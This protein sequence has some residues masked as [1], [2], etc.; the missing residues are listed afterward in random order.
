MHVTAAHQR[1]RSFG[2]IKLE[3]FKNT[4]ARRIAAGTLAESDLG[5]IDQYI[6]NNQVTGRRRRAG[7]SLA[8]RKNIFNSLVTTREFLSA[9]YATCTTEDVYAAIPRF[10]TAARAD[11]KP[12]FGPSAIHELRRELKA[13]CLFL[14][15]HGY[16]THLDEK[17]IRKIAVPPPNRKTFQDTDL[18]KPEEIEA[19]LRACT[20]SRDRAIIATLYEGGL[21][22]VEIGRLKWRDVEFTQHNVRITV[23][24]KTDRIRVVPCP[25]AK[26]Y[27]A[28]WRRDCP[29]P[30]EGDNLVFCSF[31]YRTD[32]TGDRKYL[33]MLDDSLRAQL[34]DIAAR[35]GVKRYRKPYQFRHTRITDLINLGVSESHVA[36]LSHGGHTRMMEVYKHVTNSDAERAVLRALGVGF[37]EEEKPRA[38]TP[39]RCLNCGEPC[40][41]T[42][43]YCYKCGEPLTE[44]ARHR[45]EELK[46]EATALDM[47]KLARL[48][49]IMESPKFK[50]LEKLILGE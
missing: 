34:K 17:R 19:M 45:R 33:P 43:D 20:N 39:K 11:G 10:E 38:L 41:P 47:T 42:S 15:E 6:H 18:L 31:R 13:F 12:R 30:P 37:G 32:A 22:P 40:G 25:M 9:P 21:R 35:A 14:I 3:Y 50:E 4:A 46:A 2:T 24:E 28:T 1:D 8:R 16:N 48:I 7:I 5:L 49:Q 36:Q 27:L 23:S 44:E 26:E 29:Y